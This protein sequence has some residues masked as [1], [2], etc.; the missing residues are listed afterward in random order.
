M[1][2]FLSLDAVNV[3]LVFVVPGYIISAFR[4]HFITGQ[5]VSGPDYYVRLLTLSAVNFIMAG[6]TIYLAIAWDA[7]PVPRLFVWLFVLGISPMFIGIVSGL[8]SKREWLRKIYS[9]L[10]LSPLHVIPTS[11][12][13][14]FSTLTESWILVVLKDGTKFAGLWG[15]R[16]FA[17]SRPDERD[18]L[19]EQVFEIPDDGGPWTSTNKSVFI[20]SGEI[21]TIEFV[22]TDRSES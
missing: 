8:S 16:S 7:G 15:G 18:L 1:G 6:W 10:G 3:A 13:Y 14:Q 19:I 5:K 22:P 11:W 4:A 17:S 9:R 20:A 21:R 12:E 2:N